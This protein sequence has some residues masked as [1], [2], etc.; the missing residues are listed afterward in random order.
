MIVALVLSLAFVA[1][2]A[3]AFGSLWLLDFR[4]VIDMED[5]ATIWPGH[6]LF[7]IDDADYGRNRFALISSHPSQYW[8]RLDA[9]YVDELD[10]IADVSDIYGAALRGQRTLKFIG[11]FSFLLIMSKLI[12][13]FWKPDIPWH[14]AIVQSNDYPGELGVTVTVRSSMESLL[15][16]V[17]VGAELSI[18]SGKEMFQNF[19][20]IKLPRLMIGNEWNFAAWRPYLQ[21]SGPMYFNYTPPKD[22][23][24]KKTLSKM[25]V[26]EATMA[27]TD[28]VHAIS[29][30]MK[31]VIVK[32]YA[33]EWE[34]G[35]WLTKYEKLCLNLVR[36]NKL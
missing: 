5:L 29:K 23:D 31:R 12:P 22:M 30:A 20:S 1:E 24:Y 19:K 28:P 26:E 8:F 15:W 17:R 13:M 7:M 6:D 34:G 35:R 9:L 32:R 16:W 11:F 14:E 4:W 18:Q 25:A 27:E 3:G 21:N 36:R 33:W 2:G 10:A